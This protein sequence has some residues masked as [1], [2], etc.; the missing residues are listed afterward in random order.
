MHGVV[1]LR[2]CASLAWTLRWPV[3]VLWFA[4]ALCAP[5]WAQAQRTPLKPAANGQAAQAKQ[6]APISSRGYDAEGRLIQIY[7]AIGIGHT[8]SA[9]KLAEQLVKDLP[10][11]ALA[12]LVYG[13]LLMAQT[14]PLQSFGAVP[15]ATAR[16]APGVL[17]ELREESLL[18]MRAL[19]EKPPAGMVPSALVRLSPRNRHAIAVDASRARLYV[20]ENGAQG[21]RL[22]ADYYM[23]VGK[24]GIDKNLEGD[25]RTPLG[26]YFITNT[27]HPKTLKDFYGA[28]ALPINYPNPFDL[29]RGK[30]GSG[31]WLHGTPPEQFARAPKASDGCIVLSNPDLERIL[32]TVEIRT[33]PVVIAHKLDWVNPNQSRPEI[34]AFEQTWQQWHS[35]KSS[36]DLARTLSYYTA[37][38]DNYGRKLPDW[39]R[40]LQ[41]EMTRY[42][43]LSVQVKDMAMLHWADSAGS[44]TMVVTFSEVPTGPKVRQVTGPTK[45]QYWLRSPAATGNQWK[46]F[47]EGVIG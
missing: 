45:R 41:A 37:D 16:A 3:L 19:R 29:R 9:L 10:H 25:Q 24:L 13:D 40:A 36:G 46:M 14:K 5:V 31:I 23:S 27:L 44:A 33:T 26:I 12:Q 32:R 38:F 4:A 11:F 15:E 22:I 42:K 17:S 18:R 30:T 8:R 35:A 39:S 21:V 28:G 6:A 47:F 34:S 7:Q 43:G 20:F 1:N 2:C